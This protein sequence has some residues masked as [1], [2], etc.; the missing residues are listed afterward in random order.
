MRQYNLTVQ[1]IR[2][3]GKEHFYWKYSTC[4]YSEN[5]FFRSEVVSGVRVKVSQP[6]SLLPPFI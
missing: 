6:P 3:D 2:N 5:N 1:Y 4:F